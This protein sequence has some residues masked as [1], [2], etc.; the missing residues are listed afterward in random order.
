MALLAALVLGTC[1]G[2]LPHALGRPEPAPP[3][4]PC[5]EAACFRV[6]TWNVHAIPFMAPRPSAR[7]RNVAVK[8]HEQQPDVVLLQEVWSHAYARQLAR[9]LGGA[10]RPVAATGCGRPFPCGGLLVLVRIASGWMP[11]APTFVAYDDS[12]PWYRLAEWDGIA[13]KGFLATELVR[14]GAVIAI[15]DTHLQAG[16]ARHRRDYSDIRRR[17]LDQLAS[18]LARR[19]GGRAVVVGGD[20]NT[21]PGEE[22]GL[23][24]SHLALLGTDRTADLRLA[25]G[26]CGTRPVMRRPARWLDYVLTRDLPAAAAADR[27]VNRRVDDPFSDHD[28]VLVRLEPTAT[29]P[30]P[31]AGR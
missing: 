17:Q 29:A 19:F 22:S 11:T 16:Y 23:Y 9:N 25:C 12:A 10:Y 8:I 26:A 21:A 20:F 2:C 1:S 27:I 13:K 24:E 7:L 4:L 14:G 3:L 18:T 6:L 15:V 28:A 5:A 30:P 31:A